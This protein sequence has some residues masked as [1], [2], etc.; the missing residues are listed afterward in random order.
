[1]KTSWPSLRTWCG[2]RDQKC[3]GA[4]S[5]AATSGPSSRLTRLP[6]NSSPRTS[7]AADADTYFLQTISCQNSNRSDGLLSS[8]VRQ[9]FMVDPPQA[10][11][12]HC[13][14]M[15]CKQRLC[16]SGNV[17]APSGSALFYQGLSLALNA[18]LC[19]I[20]W[21]PPFGRR[22]YFLGASRA[23]SEGLP[24]SV[25]LESRGGGVDRLLVEML[26]DQHRPDRQAVAKAAGQGHRRDGR[27]RRTA[28]CCRS[29]RTRAADRAPA[30]RR[31]AAGASPSPAA[32]ASAGDRRSPS[33]WS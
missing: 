31:A 32:S 26:A 15:T 11:A 1:M 27:S 20:R 13:G 18:R 19:A 12:S 14:H 24:I 22:S 2:L 21:R 5:S 7:V 28:P 16:R 4:S 29:F 17:A 3:N 33:A 6:E 8:V 25:G 30:A 9:W 23:P 10:R